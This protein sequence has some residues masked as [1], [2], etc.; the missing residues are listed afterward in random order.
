MRTVLA[1][2]AGIALMAVGA[3]AQTSPVARREVGSLVLENIPPVPPSLKESLRRWENVR[4]AAFEDWLA[5]GSMLISTRFGAT[6]QLHRV[7]FPGG[8][9]QQVTFYDEPISAAAAQPGS[10]D[11]YLFLRDVGGAEYF[12]VYSGG[13]TGAQPQIT[14]DGTRNQALVFS[15]DGKTAAWASVSKGEQDYAIVTW[16]PGEPAGP[17]V[18]FKGHGE[19]DPIAFSPDGGTLLFRHLISVA[20]QQ[21]FLLDL[22][23]GVAAQINPTTTEIAYGGGVF[24]SDGK[25]LILTSDEGSDV[26]RLV[27]YDLAAKGFSPLTGAG[28]WDVEDVDLSPD[29]RML[30]WTVNEDGRSRLY[31]RPLAGGALTSVALAEGVCTAL[32]FSRDSKTL[33]IGWAPTTSPPDVWGLDVASGRLDRW[34]SSE[35]GGLDP[36]QMAAP[37]LIH[38]TSFDGRPIPA[39]IYRPA[40]RAGRAPVIISIH[41]GPEGQER[42]TFSPVYQYWVEH[43]G[44]AVITPNVRGS[45]G[46]GKAYLA[47][48]DGFKRQD[49]V[50][51]IGALIAW[52]KAQPDL[53]GERI[54]VTGGSYGGFM[55]LSAFSSYGDQLAGAY[56]VV[57]MSYLVTFLV[58][59]EA[60]RRDLRRVK[61]GDERDPAMRAFMEKTAPLN[62][63]ARMTKPLFVVA[64]L[65]DPRVPYTEGEQLI[66]KVRAQGDEVWYM[67]AKDEGH[68][69]R[70]K[71]NRDAQRE[72]ETLFFEKVFGLPPS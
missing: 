35:M 3:A 56:D 68:G 59:T 24:T 54:V 9:R 7:A 51:D 19:I 44:A 16:R 1:L 17:R 20:S 42:P 11:R 37:S 8:A 18:A 29:G 70:K 12:N 28:P 55:T 38:V 30:A 71:A 63:T 47:L 61:Y 13:L 69:F 41:G 66:A 27:R 52:I 14:Q 57:G 40:A 65:N 43:L 4:S 32:R 53:D 72:A 10:A 25:S 50:K 36:A 46:Y 23:T 22:A 60:Y 21:L 15:R 39:F 34:T 33:A 49:T 45:T 67:L 62:N 58:H 31:L 64:G 26:A 6:A 48:D 2:L 5:D